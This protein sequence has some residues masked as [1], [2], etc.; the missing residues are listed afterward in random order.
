MTEY[1]WATVPAHTRI[2]RAPGP[3]AAL[4]HLL[5]AD[6]DDAAPLPPVPDFASGDAEP[7]LPLAGL[8]PRIST[9]DV[10]LRHEFPYS[11]EQVYLRSGAASRLAS[12]VER[13]PEPFGLVV[14][15]G[16]RDP[17]LQQ[18]LFDRAYAEPG[19]PPG[20]VAAPTEDPARPTPHSTGGT[21][22]LS[23]SFE[24]QPLGLGTAFDEFSEHA[25]T[26][27]LEVTS[28]GTTTAQDV[29]RELRRL[30]FS[31]LSAAGFVVLARE[32][33]HF[34]YGTRLWSA[35]TGAPARYHAA[36]RPRGDLAI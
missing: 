28:S 32:W 29:A 8:S 31:V 19:L 2:Q 7:L 15:D 35:V 10:Y 25:F 17:R 6:A 14:F 11:V 21:A 9:L 12:A 27:S 18:F 16:W 26:R 3:F 22:D 33:W 1:A 24:G 30:L 4:P 20:F 36:P 5:D 34:E 13:L 23:L